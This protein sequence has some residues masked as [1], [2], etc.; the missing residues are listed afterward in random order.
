MRQDDGRGTADELSLGAW[1]KVPP[2]HAP[3]QALRA[4][5]REGNRRAPRLSVS[6]RLS[7][8]VEQPRYRRRQRLIRLHAEVVVA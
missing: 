7:S 8:L 6:A 1:L 3:G 2:G 5:Q 4:P